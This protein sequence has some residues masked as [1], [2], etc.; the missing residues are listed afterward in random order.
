[1]K[2]I[3]TKANHDYWYKIK[4]FN[5]MEDIQ[6]FIK[7]CKHEILIEKNP[8]TSNEDFRFWDGMKPDD[9]PTIKDCPLH[10]TIYNGYIE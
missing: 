3:I 8:Y 1:M 7:E 10:I 4:A 9:I 2:T 5:T 6:R